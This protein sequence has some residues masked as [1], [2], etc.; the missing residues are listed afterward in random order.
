L[1]FL[2]WL[3]LVS[4]SFVLKIPCMWFCIWSL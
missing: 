1:F 4:Y 2:I 3:F